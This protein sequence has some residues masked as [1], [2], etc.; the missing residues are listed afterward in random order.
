MRCGRAERS[1]IFGPRSAKTWTRAA[2][3]RLP[4]VA[5]ATPSNSPVSHTLSTLRRN[6]QRVKEKVS[7]PSP[8]VFRRSG[9]TGPNPEQPA[10]ERRRSPMRRLTPDLS[11]PLE[12]GEPDLREIHLRLGAG[13]PLDGGRAFRGAALAEELHQLDLELHDVAGE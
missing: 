12:V 9:V 3:G 13:L 10:V 5:S 1:I 6:L 4:P 11:R 7:S 2:A 8:R